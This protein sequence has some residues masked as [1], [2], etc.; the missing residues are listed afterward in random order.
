MGSRCSRV[1][2]YHEVRERRKRRRKRGAF[3]APL[4]IS[5]AILYASKATYI[6][7]AQVLFDQS[8]FVFSIHQP[9]AFIVNKYTLAKMKNI[10][11]DVDLLKAY[12]DH[13]STLDQANT[14]ETCR[15]LLCALGGTKIERTSCIINFHRAEKS[16]FVL[17]NGFIN[18]LKDLRGFKT[19]VIKLLPPYQDWWEEEAFA[20]A[21]YHDTMKRLF[22]NDI[23]NLIHLDEALKDHLGPSILEYMR[24]DFWCL[25]YHPRAHHT[26]SPPPL[27]NMNDL[28]DP[29]EVVAERGRPFSYLPR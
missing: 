8:T 18:A 9:L 24:Y 17:L 19:V 25:V 14:F 10:C 1:R 21:T 5:S 27:F 6:E 16:S 4:E 12:I 20:P 29:P 3:Q 15:L 13:Y 26:G 22:T 7:A 28:A 2:H 11:I 23:A